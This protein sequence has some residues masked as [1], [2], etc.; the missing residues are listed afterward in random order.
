MYTF[1]NEERE[2]PNRYIFVEHLLCDIYSAGHKMAKIEEWKV[3]YSYSMC[4]CTSS[5]LSLSL[6]TLTE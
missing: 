4:P 6:I 5:Y 1:N 2:E 3:L